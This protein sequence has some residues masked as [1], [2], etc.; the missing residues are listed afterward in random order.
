[1]TRKP[2]P[3]L[4]VPA[5]LV[6]G[7]ALPS[8]ALAQQRKPLVDIGGTIVE[9]PDGN[10]V[11]TRPNSPI[12]VANYMTPAQVADVI[13][14]TRTL[15]VTVP[16]QNW[17]AACVAQHRACR[18]MAGIYRIS[19]QIVFE[20]AGNLATGL[21]VY[22]ESPGQTIFES[23][24][25]GG[26]PFI[27]QASGGDPS[28]PVSST[29]AYLSGLAFRCNYAGPCLSIGKADYSDQINEF[30]LWRLS[31][32]NINGG[33]GS[34]AYEFNAVFSGY[35]FANGSTAASPGRIATLGTITGGGGYADGTYPQV[36]LTGSVEGS[37]AQAT[38]T[39]SGN[40]VTGVAITY[41]GVLYKNGDILTASI[42]GGG[43]GFSVPVTAVTNVQNDIY[44]IRQ[45]AFTTYKIGGSAGWNFVHLTDSFSYGNSFTTPDCEIVA[46]CFKIDSPN[47]VRN[48][49]LGGT[50]AYSSYGYGV[51]A[52]SGDLV[53]INPNVNAN[54][55]NF[56]S[57]GTGT[58]AALWTKD[59]VART[60]APVF[61]SPV[62]SQNPSGTAIIALASGANTVNMSEDSAGNFFLSNGKSGGFTV[63][64]QAGPG[65]LQFK[66]NGAQVAAMFGSTAIFNLRTTAPLVGSTGYAVATLPGSPANGDRAFVTDANSC[67]FMTP[68]TGGGSTLCPVI[69]LGGWKAG[70]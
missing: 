33:A 55:A 21:T 51:D 65:A 58:R 31:V 1:M 53:A 27:L 56:L 16:V 57:P 35:V 36:V 59:T 28:D 34:T 46:N 69:Y 12:D 37:L 29:Y 45:S 61:T 48:T 64:D 52:T 5:L 68:V 26:P 40:Q 24:Y 6:A 66:V 11:L 15:D 10:T 41:G 25:T 8:P 70:G 22:S 7:L 4:L 2:G 23:S 30:T 54:P 3:C 63:L 49:S 14:G 50:Y 42:P 67:I 47:A 44:R 9:L 39:V 17:L 60:N 18:A 20:Q 43:S 38:V 19:G 62:T 13:A 32:Q